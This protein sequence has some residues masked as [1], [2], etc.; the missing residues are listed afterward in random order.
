MAHLSFFLAR[1]NAI[2]RISRPTL[3]LIHYRLLNDGDQIGLRVIQ[4]QSGG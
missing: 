1:F 2:S 4:I 3:V